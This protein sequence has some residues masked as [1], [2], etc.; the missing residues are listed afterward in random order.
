[1][2][3]HLGVTRL[4]T[5]RAYQPSQGNDQVKNPLVALTIGIALAADAG[6]ADQQAGNF[7]FKPDTLVLS[8]SVYVGT[9]SLL[10]PNVTVLPPGC[11]AGTVQVPLIAGGTTPVAVTCSTAI[12]DGSFPGVFTNGAADGHFGVTS[13]IYVDNLTTEGDLLGTLPIPTDQIVT[14]FSSKSELAVN[15]SIDGKSITFMGYRGGAG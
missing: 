15:R 4:G 9:A 11:I 13:P 10:V 12:A 3:E 5:R 1:M 7:K 2:V 6:A 8:R 14:S